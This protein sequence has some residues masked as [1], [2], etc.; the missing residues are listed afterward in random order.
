MGFYQAC[1]GGLS[2]L[3]A[4][5][6]VSQPTRR[7]VV[8]M[9]RQNNEQK[10]ATRDDSHP[11]AQWYKAYSLAIAAD[12]L[13]GPYLLPLYRDEYSLE[14]A[15][16]F[17][18]YMADF[19]STAIGACFVGTLA[20]KYG[21]KLACMM[22]CLLYALSC[23][24]TV[25]PATPL[26]FVGRVLGGIS[27]SIL[28]AAFDSW[29][30]TNFHVL[31]LGNHGCDLTRTFAATSVV[32]SLVAILAGVVGEALVWATG[33]KKS[34]FLMSATLL[35]FALQ[36]I[37]SR[38]AE[39]HGAKASP[40]SDQATPLRSPWSVLR[41]PSVLTL[42]FVSTMFEGSM[43]LFVFYWM[44]ILGS[45]HKPTTTEL[46]YSIIYSSFMAAAMAGALGYNIVMNKR[47]ARYSQL[48]IGVLLVAN[49]CFV[50][51]AGSKSETT[52]FWLFCLLQVCAGIYGPCIGYLKAQLIDDQART[53]VYSLMRTPLNIVAILSMMAT[54][55][56]R[57]V[58]GIFSS[59]SIMLTAAVATMWVASLRGMP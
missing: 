25:I 29:V 54:K 18:L 4:G 30:V 20:D 9:K 17:N 10:Q 47:I 35:W 22:Y 43:N 8:E 44:S 1:F 57:N 37:W 59:C 38:W 46:P 15:L 45:L 23:F 48:L 55:D 49:V 3:C 39:N 42:A 27:T 52:T 58:G 51:L 21:R 13:Q 53:S 6:L 2:A 31:R 12:W 56:N 7:Q 5:L 32:N 33:S 40:K 24:L 19:V 50:R 41:Q 36:T 28:F 34:P 14:P 11:E 26:L 16:M